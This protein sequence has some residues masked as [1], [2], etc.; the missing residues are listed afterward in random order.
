M[1][2]TVARA[3]LLRMRSSS[4]SAPTRTQVPASAATIAFSM[5]VMARVEARERCRRLPADARD[6]PARRVLHEHE[7]LLERIR[8]AV[9]AEVTAVDAHGRLRRTLHVDRA[10]GDV[11]VL[12]VL[13]GDRLRLGVRRSG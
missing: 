4:S 11:D 12:P 2:T 5:R 3:G 8:L 10:D 7:R 13:R 9:E 1:V 6:L